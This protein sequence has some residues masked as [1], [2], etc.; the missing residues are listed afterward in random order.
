VG[1]NPPIAHDDLSVTP[2]SCCM[3]TDQDNG[4]TERDRQTERD[5]LI[6]VLNHTYKSYSTPDPVG[7][8][9]ETVDWRVPL[10]TKKQGFGVISFLHSFS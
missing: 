3:S 9:Q 8:P 1:V 4:L 2:V 6:L 5:R 10:L 7:V